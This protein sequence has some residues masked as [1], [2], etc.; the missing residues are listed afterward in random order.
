M[1]EAGLPSQSIVGPP[2]LRPPDRAGL[3]PPGRR[4][5]RP[6]GLRLLGSPPG[7]PKGPSGACLPL[8]PEE[9]RSER[10]VSRAP[11]P[12]KQ[13]SDQRPRVGKAKPRC[14]SA[15]SPCF[16]S[17][18]QLAPTASAGRS[19]GA[20]GRRCPA[21]ACFLPDASLGHG[22]TVPVAGIASPDQALKWAGRKIQTD[23]TR[24]A[25]IT[26][27]PATAPG[28]A[29]AAFLSSTVLPAW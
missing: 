22:F 9:K 20:A 28:G 6:A 2:G 8:F 12:A 27:V 11:G 19:S 15:A 5:V 23:E 24:H 18:S 4:G 21:A 10:R 26:R 25:A 14:S 29:H 7:P 16:A 1:P 13:C 17:I 3:A